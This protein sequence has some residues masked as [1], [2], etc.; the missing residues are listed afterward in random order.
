MD[1][2]DD[3]AKTEAQFQQMALDNQRARAK[4]SGQIASRTHCKECGD[5]VPEARQEKVAGANTA[6]HAKPKGRGDESMVS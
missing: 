6:P 5:P 2:I 1:V 3:A 4:S